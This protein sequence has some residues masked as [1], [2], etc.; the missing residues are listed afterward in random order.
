MYK[1][2]DSYEIEETR[3]VSEKELRD[4]YKEDVKETLFNWWNCGDSKIREDLM[5]ELASVY[6][7][8]IS[9]VIIHLKEDMG[10][11]IEKEN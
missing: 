10:Y 7:C 4:M 1:V 6:T 2:V 3:V 5:E 8:D 9:L 11:I